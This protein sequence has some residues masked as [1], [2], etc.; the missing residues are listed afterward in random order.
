[1][2]K[3]KEYDAFCVELISAVKEHF[4]QDATIEVHKI[5]KNNSIVLDGLNIM[6]SG[7][8]VSPNFYLQHFFE[9][10]QAGNSIEQLAIEI[11]ESY[12]FALENREKMDFDLSYLFCESRIIFRL[13][14]FELNKE[15]AQ[16]IP[17]IPFLDMMI[18][19][20]ALLRQD[21]NG[22]GTVRITNTLM[23]QWGIDAKKLFELARENTQRLFPSKICGMFSMM[24][25]ILMESA[26]DSPQQEALMELLERQDYN[27][28]YVVTNTAGING[29][30]V[31]L[32][33]DVLE[34]VARELGGDFYILPSSIHEVLAVPAQSAVSR[35]DLYEMV[36]DVNGS[37]VAKDEI[38]SESIYK[39]CQSLR[40]IVCCFAS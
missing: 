37:C 1:M 10:Y 21:E 11:A 12:F 29:A 3:Q 36:H 17:H 9:A 14:S 25:D 15:L 23:K 18:T 38:L 8:N 33:Q 24:A 30:A 40:K 6:I 13:V 35:N 32:Y 31:I 26:P 28:P 2:E 5:K 34:S 27:E 19:F 20:H 4:A 39:Y 7:E 22:I 16:E